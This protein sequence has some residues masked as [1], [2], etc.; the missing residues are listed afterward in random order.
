M[1]TYGTLS[2][3]FLLQF[4]DEFVFFLWIFCWFLWINAKIHTIF[5]FVHI[6]AP[7]VKAAGSSL[8][9]F[10]PYPVSILEGPLGKKSRR[11]VCGLFLLCFKMVLN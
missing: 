9:L 7:P 4:Y 11:R 5:R 6:F 8:P 3:S 2:L 1:E 10:Q